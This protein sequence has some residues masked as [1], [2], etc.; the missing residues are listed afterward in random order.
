MLRSLLAVL[1]LAAAPFCAAAQ[2]PAPLEQALSAAPD[3]QTPPERVA[4]RMTVNGQSILVEIR[5]GGEDGETAYA[6]L[7]PPSEDLL[8]E[9]QAE[10][11]AGFSSD[12]ETDAAPDSEPGESYSVGQ[13]DAEGL[14]DAIGGAA[15]LLREENGRLVY[16]FTPQSLPGQGGQDEERSGLLDNLT[17]EIEVDAERG[18]VVRVNFTLTESFKPN[19]A[20]RVNEFTLEQRFVHEPAIDG[21]RF[22]GM[23]MAMAGSAVFQSFSQRMDIDLVSVRYAV[24]GTLEAGAE[25]P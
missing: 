16:G 2:L 1:A 4:L 5:P 9:E 6:L 11:W 12:D 18:Q 15:T 14:R 13:F 24:P 10:M 25:S 21:P 20:A 17:G 7:E 22:A 23:T 19:I 3:D 8:S